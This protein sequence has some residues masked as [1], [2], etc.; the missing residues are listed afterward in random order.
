M[1]FN[2][3]CFQ[4]VDE[5][6]KRKTLHGEEQMFKLKAVSESS[7][8]QWFD[9]IY[10]QESCIRKFQLSTNFVSQKLMQ[11]HAPPC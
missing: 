6:L 5:F 1:S 2:A 3:K 9:E 10:Q 4:G 7:F 11:M 8:S